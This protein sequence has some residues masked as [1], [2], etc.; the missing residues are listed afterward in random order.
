MSQ[1]RMYEHQCQYAGC[2]SQMYAKFVDMGV[3][4]A[5]AVAAM[6]ESG[7]NVEV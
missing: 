1:L 7:T 2:I 5:V 6:Y 4:K 3:C